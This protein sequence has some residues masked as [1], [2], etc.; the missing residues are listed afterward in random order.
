MVQFRLR[1]IQ[2]LAAI[3]P[4]AAFG[5]AVARQQAHDGE[6]C[7]T[8]A[9]TGFPDDGERLAGVQVKTQAVDRVHFAIEGV[10]ADAQ[11]VH[12]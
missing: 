3:E 7:L 10:E 5:A 12:G 4:D 9:R 2:D 1:Q 8:F 11:V 6:G